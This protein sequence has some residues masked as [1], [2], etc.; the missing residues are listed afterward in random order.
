MAGITLEQAEAQLQRYLDAEAKVLSRQ[1]YKIADR[2][3][4]GA[5]LDM[6]Q[7][8]VATWD[9]RVKQLSARASGHGRARTMVVRG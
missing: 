6:I 5:S 8:G 4:F 2:E 1:R 3:L 7:S 9:A